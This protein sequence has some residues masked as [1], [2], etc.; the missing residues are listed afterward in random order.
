M[1]KLR[2]RAFGLLALLAVVL[3]GGQARAQAL[4]ADLSDHFIAITTGFIGTDVLLFGAIEGEGDVIVVLRGPSGKELVRRKS[5]IAG[6]F[7]NDKDMTFVNV[8]SFYSVSSNRPLNEIL[9]PAARLRHEIGFDTLRL[10]PEKPA[11][12]A[13]PAMVEEFRAALIRN[14]K[15]AELYLEDPGK[16]NFLGSRLFRTRVYFPSNLAT[17]SYTADV[18]LVRDGAVVSA[19][20]TPLFVSKVGFSAEIYDFAYQWPM[21]Y[22]V[23]AV[24]LALLAGWAAAL[25]FRRT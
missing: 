17:G 7:I 5:R 19:Q 18:Y 12:M 1:S 10:A 8:P 6:I 24:L 20:S 23:I 15:N 22:G 21:A 11:E 9:A 13:N 16:V 14:K 2:H 4:V 25:V 3:A